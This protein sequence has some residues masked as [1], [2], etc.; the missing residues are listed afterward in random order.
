MRHYSFFDQ[1]LI[2][3]D[4]LLNPNQSVDPLSQAELNTETPQE[5]LSENEKRQSVAL[6]RVNHCGEVCAQALY[7]GQGLVARNINLANQLFKAADEEHEHLNWCANRIAALGGRRSFLNPVW[8]IGSFGIGIV[9]GLSGD[10]TSL[11]FLAETEYQVSRHLKK[12]LEKISPKDNKSREILTQMLK[13]EERH[14]THAIALGGVP[15]PKA[16]CFTMN[17]FSKIMTVTTRYI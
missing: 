6:M 17:F 12:H 13:D 5:H 2:R 11:G 10:K 7:L 16:V 1:V 9:A 15:L 14:A 4:K 8:A 3:F